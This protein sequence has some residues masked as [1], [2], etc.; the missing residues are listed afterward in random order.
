MGTEDSIILV[1]MLAYFASPFEFFSVGG[2]AAVGPIL[3]KT[4]L[5]PA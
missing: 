4:F 3:H 5:S 2:G 1:V